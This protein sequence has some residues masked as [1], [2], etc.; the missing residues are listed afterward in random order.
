M[1]VTTAPDVLGFVV[2]KKAAVSVVKALAKHDHGDPCGYYAPLAEQV[3]AL[4]DGWVVL[5]V[6]VEE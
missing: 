3:A 4:P 5:Y 2:S 1:A 6:G